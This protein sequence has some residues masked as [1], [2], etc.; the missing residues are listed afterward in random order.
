MSI[1]DASDEPG[2][3]RA[4]EPAGTT[5]GGNPFRSRL[6][7]ATPGP[8]T[9]RSADECWDAKLRDGSDIDRLVLEGPPGG[10]PDGRVELVSTGKTDA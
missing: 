8:L 3:T 4:G 1:V 6:C 7:S 5:V 2:A 9:D 10:E